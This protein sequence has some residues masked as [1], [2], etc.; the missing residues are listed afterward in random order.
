MWQVSVNSNNLGLKHLDKNLTDILL[1]ILGMNPLQPPEGFP[2]SGI[3]PEASLYPYRIFSCGEEGG[4]RRGGTSDLV[5]K[6]MLKA[7][8]DGVD[9]ISMSLSL[10]EGMT[11]ELP[12]YD[13][14]A[15]A[16]QQI[17]DAGIAIV[18]AMGHCRCHGE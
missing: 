6:A 13:P 3:A 8:E 15:N 1:G 10:P 12:K 17:K 4:P 16:A 9:I 14:V 2:I 18:V 7:L 5:L 11:T